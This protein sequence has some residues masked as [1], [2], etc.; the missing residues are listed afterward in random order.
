MRYQDE[1]LLVFDDLLAL[2]PCHLNVIPSTVFLPDWRFLLK[3]LL[4]YFDIFSLF[5]L[6]AGIASHTGVQPL[7]Y[8][9]VHVHV[10]TH[11]H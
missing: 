9:I 3:V 7:L 6:P 10:V 8:F 2:C 1:S 4:F 5:V 11:D